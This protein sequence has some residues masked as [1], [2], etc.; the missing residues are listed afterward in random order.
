MHKADAVAPDLFGLLIRLTPSIEEA[1][2]A[3]RIGPVEKFA[4]SGKM[5]AIS[6]GDRPNHVA[7]PPAICATDCVGIHTP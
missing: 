7:R 5:L 4:K 2:Y 1:N 6:V 3:N